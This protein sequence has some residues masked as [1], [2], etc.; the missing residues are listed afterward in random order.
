MEDFPKTC[1]S[2]AFSFTRIFCFPY[3]L[4]YIVCIQ[5]S[6]QHL[7]CSQDTI[8]TLLP[9]FYLILPTNIFPCSTVSS[10]L[11]PI[12]FTDMCFYFCK[13]QIDSQSS[14]QDSSR[15]S[16]SLFK[17]SQVYRYLINS[18]LKAKTKGYSVFKH[19]TS[20]QPC[21]KSTEITQY[22]LIIQAM[23]KSYITFSQIPFYSR[24]QMGM[25]II[26]I[27]IPV[28]SI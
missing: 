10:L 6:L 13:D 19:P 2:S 12:S 14:Q 8:S 15:S 7:Q 18:A 9:G 4:I 22:W 28:V 16:E 1:L 20:V 17:Y 23:L 3:N 21:I 27:I 25:Q 26:F 11:P 5:V 24:L